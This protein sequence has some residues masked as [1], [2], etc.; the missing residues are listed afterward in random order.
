M[1]FAKGAKATP[2]YFRARSGA[3]CNKQMADK[4][5]TWMVPFRAHKQKALA[6]IRKCFP[7][8]AFVRISLVFTAVFFFVRYALR[9]SLPE[10]DANWIELY[11]ICLASMLVL[12]AC[13]SMVALTPPRI[14]V[15]Q[16]GVMVQQGQ[17]C[18]WHRFKDM[19]SI[20]VD[21]SVLPLSLLRI[22]LLTHRD[23]KAYPIDPA[24]SVEKL[25]TLIDRSRY[26]N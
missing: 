17:H 6:E 9:R 24:V 20:R 7:V 3:L 25:R 26:L 13:G 23:E 14:T 22:S 12:I 18:V 1:S 8:M 21:E 19:A 10:I 16:K 2:T 11:L 4:P 5:I 15:S